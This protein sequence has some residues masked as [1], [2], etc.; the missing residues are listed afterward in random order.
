MGYIK[1]YD[2]LAISAERKIVLDIIE[3]G[4][5]AIQPEQ[6]L[7]NIQLQGNSLA[8]QEHTFDLSSYERIFLLGFGKG[9]G[10][11][12]KKL[13]E[14]LGEK[15]TEGC[16]IDVTLEHFTKVQF[17]LGTH[18][19]PSEQNI[20][21]T[22]QAIKQLSHITEKDLVLVVICGGGSAMLVAPNTISLDQKIEI[23]KALLESGATISEMNT[24]RK[25]ISRVKGGGLAKIVYPATV[26]SLIFSDVPGNDLSVIASGPTEKDP[27][28][29][30]DAQNII[31][32]YGLLQKLQFP[33]NDLIETPKENKYFENVHNL[34][35]LSN[36]TALEAMQ[37]KALLMQW[38]ASIYSEKF[39]GEAKIAGK[40]LIFQTQEG[41]ILLI[42]GETTVKV[43][44]IHGKGGRNQEL[45][46]SALNHVE[47]DVIL[48]SLDSDGWD[49]SSFAGAI[50]DSLTLKKAKGLNIDPELY[51]NENN[52][53]EFF[54][55]IKDGV[56]TGRL[57]SN[58]SDL[59]VILK[60]TKRVSKIAQQIISSQIENS[61]HIPNY[62]QNKSLKEN[63]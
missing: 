21:F 55:K 38:K 53:L 1:N 23:N 51:L 30:N 27:S 36:L 4:L 12:A 61:A 19:L 18:P 2:S 17:T 6:V 31:E 59:I 15:L 42:G 29:I 41:T 9:S 45:V 26:I 49:N 13:E 3:A 20:S 40:E 63:R 32:K 34:L 47:D 22:E 5:A 43:R 25:H 35:L 58:V 8:I 52:S 48:C 46:L 10:A 7:S 37:Q 14:I 60:K 28:T 39:Q 57:P 54:Q 11:V 56:S 16:V 62:I 33:L 44:N 50:G 24:I